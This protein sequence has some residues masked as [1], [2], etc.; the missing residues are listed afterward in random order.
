VSDAFKDFFNSLPNDD[1]EENEA[2]DL[3]R[4]DYTDDFKLYMV[5]APDVRVES[6]QGEWGSYFEF[7]VNYEGEELHCRYMFS[8]SERSHW[9]RFKEFLFRQ[10][11]RDFLAYTGKWTRRRDFQIAEDTAT[12]LVDD[13]TAMIGM[14][15]DGMFTVGYYV[16]GIEA[17]YAQRQDKWYLEMAQSLLKKVVPVVNPHV[18]DMLDYDPERIDRFY[19]TVL[20]LICGEYKP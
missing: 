17:Y 9:T 8:D 10:V 6:D 19:D 13:F 11:A 12:R 18:A 5:D 7:T 1:R 2:G 3:S 16:S 14:P 4:T 15:D 20:R